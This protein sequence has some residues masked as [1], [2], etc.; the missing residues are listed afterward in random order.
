LLAVDIFDM[1]NPFVLSIP[2][3]SMLPRCR[4]CSPGH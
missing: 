4:A 2:L 3:L 1:S